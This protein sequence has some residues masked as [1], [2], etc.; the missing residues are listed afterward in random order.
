ME[1]SY[2]LPYKRVA[3]CRGFALNCGITDSNIALLQPYGRRECA[4]F[5]VRPA[6]AI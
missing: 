5:S 6:S 1:E 3:G 2:A 4:L